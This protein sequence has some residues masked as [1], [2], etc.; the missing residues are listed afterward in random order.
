MWNVFSLC[1]L[2]QKRMRVPSYET[3]G[4]QNDPANVASMAMMDAMAGNRRDTNSAFA[5]KLFRHPRYE[6][7]AEK[8]GK[9]LRKRYAIKV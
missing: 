4:R 1:G 6:E 2:K 9:A 7:W 3:S 5:E 8:H